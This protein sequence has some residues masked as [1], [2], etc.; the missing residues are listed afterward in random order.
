MGDFRKAIADFN[1]IIK[2]DPTSPDGYYNLG[3]ANFKHGNDKQ[4]VANFNSALNRNPNLAD[5][6]G[7]RGLAQY[8]LGD[9]KNAVA[10]LKQAANLFQQQGNIQGYQQTLNLLQQIQPKQSKIYFS[11]AN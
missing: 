8:A 9:N 2:I 11:S 3:L 7:N 4:A 6:Y 1:Q 5:A 10:D